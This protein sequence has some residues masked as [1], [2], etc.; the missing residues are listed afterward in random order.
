MSGRVLGKPRDA[1]H[2]AGHEACAGKVWSKGELAKCAA[3]RWQNAEQGL[4]LAKCGANKP[5]FLSRAYSSSF[6][7]YLFIFKLPADG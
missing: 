4:V 3:P 6:H 5:G 7:F 2:R 1:G